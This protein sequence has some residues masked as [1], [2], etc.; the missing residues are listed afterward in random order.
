M[1]AGLRRSAWLLVLLSCTATPPPGRD[2][3]EPAV[4]ASPPQEVTPSA[5]EEPPPPSTPPAIAL[6]D[7]G[8][9]RRPQ[10]SGTARAHNRKALRR[11]KAGDY[12]DART[13]FAKAVEVSPDHDM[14]RF[15]LACALT[16]LGE[17]EAA[18][19]AL[20]RVL[21][22]DLMRFQGRWTDDADLEALRASEHAATIDALI[23]RLRTAYETAHDDG[24]PTYFFASEPPLAKENDNGNFADPDP[25]VYVAGAWVHEAQRFVPLVREGQFVLLDLPRRR[26]VTANKEMEEHHCDYTASL[27]DLRMVSTS[28]SPR[29][30]QQQR[31]IETGGDFLGFIRD[32]A[33][34]GSSA[35]E[36]LQSPFAHVQPE[37]ARLDAHPPKGYELNNTKLTVPGRDAP[38]ELDTPGGVLFVPPGSADPVFVLQRAYEVDA[39]GV[40]QFPTFDTTV[41]RVD[42]QT[43]RSQRITRGRGSGWVTFGPDGSLYIEVGGKTKRWPTPTSDAPEATIPRLHIALPLGHPECLCCG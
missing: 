29:A 20:S 40:N 18:R 7:I 37:G 28:P 4:E 10:I 24:V 23:G 27:D 5:A 39:Q 25:A 9:Q 38:I 19:D 21:H 42:T 1:N 13:G 8:W 43:G 33:T 17:L 35:Y 2:A 11:H 12:A 15:N 32:D 6:S 41:L 22:R 30:T 36:A 3:S 14:A 34:D 16:R 26:A 31:Q